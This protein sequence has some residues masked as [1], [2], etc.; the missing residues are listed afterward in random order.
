M[1]SPL[2][3]CL[4]SVST[5]SN[6][7]GKGGRRADSVT[8]SLGSEV[9][10]LTVGDESVTAEYTGSDGVKHSVVAQYVIAADGIRSVVRRTLGIGEHGQESLGTAINVQFD[11]DLEPYLGGRPIPIIWI[12]NGDTQGAFIPRRIHSVALQLRAPARF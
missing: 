8:I 5:C 6:D 4:L 9:T 11:A 10:D 12:I 1:H 2:S 7:P 3:G